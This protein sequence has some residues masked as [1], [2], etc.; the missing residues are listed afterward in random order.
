MDGLPPARHP[1]PAPGESAAREHV[2]TSTGA[3]QGHD[4]GHAGIGE[5][6]RHRR[7]RPTIDVSVVGLRLRPQEEGAVESVNAAFTKAAAS[8][9]W[10]GSS[11]SRTS[12]SSPGFHREHL[13]ER[14]GPR[15]DARVDGDL[16]KVL[17]WYDTMGVL[18][19]ADRTWLNT[20]DRCEGATS[21]HHRRGGFGGLRTALELVND[22]LG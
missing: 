2:P 21:D 8:A 16:V 14:G 18:G 10:K 5:I 7:T 19:A 9:R 22:G 12:R 11:G 13:R 6:R 3:A 17:A 4:R 15:H 20:S 1:D